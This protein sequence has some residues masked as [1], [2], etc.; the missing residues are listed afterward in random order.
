MTTASSTAVPTLIGSVQR[1]L[2]LL[3]AVG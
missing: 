3:E 1:A 2:R